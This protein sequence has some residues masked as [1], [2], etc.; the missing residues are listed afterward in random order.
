MFF[1]LYPEKD[2]NQVDLMHAVRF[3]NPDNYYIARM[4]YE[5]NSKNYLKFFKWKI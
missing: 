1:Q 4:I 2:M 3:D 5:D